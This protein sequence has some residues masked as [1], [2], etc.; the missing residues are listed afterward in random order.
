MPSSPT[1][2]QSDASRRNGARSPGPVSEDGKA[3][4]AR[5]GTR[6][7]LFAAELELSPEEQAHLE[8]L[9]DD[10]GRRHR[11]EGKMEAHWVRQVAMTML[12]RERLDALEMRV[13]DLAMEGAD[14]VREAGLPSPATLLRYRARLQRDHEHA[15]REIAAARE[16]RGRGTVE[17]SNPTPDIAAQLAQIE[18]E[19]AAAADRDIA[20]LLTM[21]GAHGKHEPED[22]PP[23]ALNR[24]QRRRLEARQRQAACG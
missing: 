6:H 22:T 15:M 8:A 9:L 18:A 1:A 11:P 2:A 17:N 4:S 13:L 23:F 19:A 20:R 5:N 10:L 7:G 24:A 12:R 21:R 14:S 3:R 16:A